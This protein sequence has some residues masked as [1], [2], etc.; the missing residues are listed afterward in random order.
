MAFAEGPSIGAFLERATDGARVRRV[1]LDLLRQCAALDAA[2]VDKTEMHRCAR[3]VVVAPDADA[4]T[5]LDFE[6]CADAPK[7]QNVTGAAQYLSQRWAAAQLARVGVA[8][9]VDAVRAACKRYK[10]DRADAAARAVE[11]ALGLRPPED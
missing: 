6:W 3:H 11:A 2:G 8:V 9:D 7:P 5:L 10:A 4:V 1:L